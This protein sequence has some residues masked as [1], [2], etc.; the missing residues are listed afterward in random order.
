MPAAGSC[1]ER[2]DAGLASRPMNPNTKM[3]VALAALGAVWMILRIWARRSDDRRAEARDARMSALYEERERILAESRARR[4]TEGPSSIAAVVS[5]A[6]P[7]PKEIV[8]VRCGGCRA[9]NAES[10]TVCTKCGATL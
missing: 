3:I 9:L 6:D 8:K 1:G 5:D 4:E 7:A 2:P 10:E